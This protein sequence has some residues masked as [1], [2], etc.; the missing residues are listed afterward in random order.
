MRRTGGR[1]DGRKDSHRIAVIAGD[2]IGP[3]VIEAAIPVLDRA[4][5]KHGF[6]LDWERLP[7]AAGQQRLGISEWPGPTIEADDA[8]ELRDRFVSDRLAVEMK[9]L[10]R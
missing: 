3:E 10:T 4:A 9:G 1:A 7:Y 6:S 8:L 2:G 5:K